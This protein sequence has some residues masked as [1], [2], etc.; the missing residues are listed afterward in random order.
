M[1]YHSQ[2]LSTITEAKGKVS[3]F[4]AI[5]LQ[6]LD[7]AYNFDPQ[8]KKVFPKKGKGY[9]IPTLEEVID[10]FPNI[11]IIVDLKASPAFKLLPALIKLVDKKESWNR[12]I[13][14]ST[15]DEDI[16]YFKRLKPDEILF[17]NRSQTGKR[18]LTQRI[19]NICCCLNN[20]TQYA[21]FEL[22]R[23]MYVEDYFTL[24]KSKNTINFK[25]WDTASVKCTRNSL[26]KPSRIFLFGI[27][28]IDDYKEA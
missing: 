27:N 18:L 1:L 20:D 22:N 21:G 10:R 6:G 8:G 14:Y 16:S 5:E 15:N 9:K 25:L 19:E 3:D 23:K 7:A 12:L 11:E 13:F 24:G 26:Q 17:E 2:D 4:T 28:N